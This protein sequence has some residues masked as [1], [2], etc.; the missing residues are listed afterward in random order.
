M[1]P[2]GDPRTTPPQTPDPDNG[3]SWQGDG[4]PS[5]AQGD[6]NYKDATNHGVQTGNIFGYNLIIGK[7]NVALASA[8][9]LTHKIQDFAS[10]V[11]KVSLRLRS[12]GE[13]VGA[14]ANVMNTINDL[15]VKQARR[16]NIGEKEV[17]KEAKLA[18]VR[19]RDWGQGKGKEPESE[20]LNRR[21]F[22]NLMEA[23]KGANRL[24][25]DIFK[26]IEDASD[27]LIRPQVL[28]R[29]GPQPGPEITGE[30][31]EKVTL[32]E[33]DKERILLTERDI[34]YMETDI[35]SRKTELNMMFF[36]FEFVVND[37]LNEKADERRRIV[38]RNVA[39][40]W[41]LLK[42]L[43]NRLLYGG[44]GGL[45]P[46]PDHVDPAHRPR[47]PGP[48]PDIRP[49]QFPDLSRLTSLYM[50]WVIRKGP[51]PDNPA[52]G[53]ERSQ[54][55]SWAS[56]VIIRLALSTE[57]LFLKVLA[58]ITQRARLGRTL[59]DD[60]AAI[61]KTTSQKLVVDRLLRDQNQ[62]LQQFHSQLEWTLGGLELQPSHLTTGSRS[63]S[64]G[65]KERGKKKEK[66]KKKRGAPEDGNREMTSIEIILKSQ[67]RAP[68]LSSSSL[69]FPHGPGGI[70]GPGA[71]N[72]LAG[73]NGLGGI[74][75][76][77]G[78]GHPG[79]IGG[80]GGVNG[81]GGINVPGDINGPGGINGPGP[82]AKTRNEG[83]PRQRQNSEQEFARSSPN[84][85]DRSLSRPQ[86][87]PRLKQ[88]RSILVT[89]EP[90]FVFVKE[91]GKKKGEKADKTKSRKKYR[92]QV[93]IE[94]RRP[95]RYRRRSSSP[96]N[97]SPDP[98][99]SFI[100][101]VLYPPPRHPPPPPPVSQSQPLPQMP[102]PSA[103]FV[104]G[105][106]YPPPRPPPPP[107]AVSQSQPLPQMPP[108]PGYRPRVH[109]HVGTLQ[110]ERERQREEK[111]VIEELFDDFEELY[112]RIGKRKSAR[113][114]R[115][116]EL[117]ESR[118]QKPHS[119]TAAGPSSAAKFSS[120]SDLYPDT[121]TSRKLM[122]QV[123]KTSQ[124]KMSQ[125]QK[126]M[127]KTKEDIMMARSASH[128]RPPSPIPPLWMQTKSRASEPYVTISHPD[129]RYRSTTRHPSEPDRSAI[130]H[131]SERYVNMAHPRD[132]NINITPIPRAREQRF[133]RPSSSYV[134]SRDRRREEAGDYRSRQARVEDLSEYDDDSG[135][136]DWE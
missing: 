65:R 112:G 22:K 61:L 25:S 41:R 96:D 131:T 14:T 9:D 40:C 81:P 55:N 70:Y 33:A 72:G 125:E 98:L 68:W 5:V 85:S 90:Q 29:G 1:Q 82:R 104:P 32:D 10:S 37:G 15:V 42:E 86:L 108:P 115:M 7:I 100:P 87:K 47:R 102:P 106:P 4:G 57:E 92:E 127:E 3:K 114:S 94:L 66:K 93:Y 44:G 78:I 99:A 103:S 49:L 119:R 43:A 54:Q 16:E 21:C 67:Q 80:P 23:I 75:V 59:Q 122:R 60:C 130:R 48:L 105:A 71:I 30:Q 135:G 63:K 109:I 84:T 56:A 76:P 126:Y 31:D 74:N 120:D 117:N 136:E 134:A 58:Q 129:E 20:V 38:E 69:P 12:V 101:D 52:V 128:L 13:K 6:V 118:S 28:D 17:T 77:G 50:G 51:V 62:N 121:A 95:G 2:A 83:T 88:H 116:S 73:M 110:K 111:Q 91:G 64:R 35:E 97:V 123:E 124:I 26:K 36:V 11:E 18:E 24:F 34:G 27:T 89:R 8:N 45:Q 132:L 46:R 39:D 107:P 79:G 53:L 133:E 19:N 113:L